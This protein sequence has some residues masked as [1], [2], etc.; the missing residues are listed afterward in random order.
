MHNRK[1][2]PPWLTVEVHRLIKQR[3]K[4]A[5]ISCKT[6]SSIDRDRYRK[7]RNLASKEISLAYNR[8]LNAVI[9]N[10]SEDSRGFYR[11]SNRREQIIVESLR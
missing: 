8:H 4:L 6:G 11:S 5:K 10:L 2:R 9:G 7:A 3:N 1:R